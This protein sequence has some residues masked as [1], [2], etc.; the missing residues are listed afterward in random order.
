MDTR[1]AREVEFEIGRYVCPTTKLMVPLM[2]SQPL[3]FVH[4]PMAVK[5]CPGCGR[6]HVLALADVQH[7][8][9]YGYE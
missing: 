7:P 6:E 1:D 4:W 9:V 3:A 2:A 8:P 5:S